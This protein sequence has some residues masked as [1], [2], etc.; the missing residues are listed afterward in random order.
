[1]NNVFSGQQ[2]DEKIL[3]IL[4]PHPLM[5]IISNIILVLLAIFF[6]FFITLIGA[7]VNAGFLWLI[8]L[9]FAI[10]LIVGGLWWNHKTFQE[11]LT[12][13]TDRRIVR[14]VVV[15]PFFKTKREL[16]WNEAL[17]AKSYSQNLILRGMKIG[18]L[19]VEPIA[20]TSENIIVTNVYMF[21]D[22]ANYIDKILYIFKNKPD[23]ISLIKPF[24]AKPKG[25]RDS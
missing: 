8:G 5:K 23:E 20:S 10:L 12:Y 24:I 3:Y 14:F 18:T 9:T 11:N 13:I 21:E 17:K 2:T 1:M 22:V 7:V 16:F 19:Q 25:K 4:T 6:A 15:S